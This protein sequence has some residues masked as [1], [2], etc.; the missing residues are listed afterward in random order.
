MAY[1]VDAYQRVK[2][3]KKEYEDRLNRW[4]RLC[5]SRG[6]NEDRVTASFKKVKDALQNLNA[7]SWELVEIL[8]KDGKIPNEFLAKV[9]AE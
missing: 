9:L 7:A 6:A 3:L 5:N 1:Y 8:S 2:L 4:L